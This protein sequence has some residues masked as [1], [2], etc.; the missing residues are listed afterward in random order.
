MNENQTIVYLMD[1]A[2]DEIK[3]GSELTEGM[4]VLEESPTAR[5][6]RFDTE[7]Y[8]IRAQ[9]FRRVTRL[10]REP[11]RIFEG[12]IMV[13]FIGEWVDG[14]QEIHEGR[15]GAAWLVRKEN[16]EPESIDPS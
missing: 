9:R 16:T 6:R 15:Q 4:W 2:L 13:R 7:E 11:S 10:T 5:P 3:F 12:G 1:P 8:E 14:Y